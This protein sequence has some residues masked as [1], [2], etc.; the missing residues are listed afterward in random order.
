MSSPSEPEV[1]EPEVLAEEE[2]KVVYD[3][4]L[5]EEECLT[6]GS[7]LTSSVNASPLGLGHLVVRVTTDPEVGA[8]AWYH[9][10]EKTVNIDHAVLDIRGDEGVLL[11]AVLHEL[12]HAN[13]TTWIIPKGTSGAVAKA[14]TW[15]EEIRIERWVHDR[16]RDPGELRT[17][18]SWLLGSLRK[19]PWPTEFAVSG[20]WALAVGRYFSGVCAWSEVEDLDLLVRTELGDGRVT[21]M[22]EILSEAL[23]TEVEPGEPEPLLALAQEWVDLFPDAEEPMVMLVL[24]GH[25]SE[26][27]DDEE[28][29]GEEGEG[30]SGG[31]EGDEG[32]EPT[33]GSAPSKTSS[34]TPDDDAPEDDVPGRDLPSSVEDPGVLD[35][36]EDAPP[37]KSISEETAEMLKKK[38]DELATATEDIE[39]PEGPLERADPVKAMRDVV[40]QDRPARR[41]RYGRLNFEEVVPPAAVRARAASLSRTLENLHLPAVAKMKVASPGPPGRLH[42][43]EM[44]RKSADRSAGRMSMATPWKST[45]RI[46]TSHKPIRVGTMTDTSGSMHW[47]ERLVAEFAWITATAGRKIGARTA[48]VTFGDRVSPVVLPEQVPHT[49]K[50]YAADGGTEHFDVA[51]AAMDGF[52][53]L[54]HN[55]GSTK[56]LFIVSDGQLVIHDEPERAR[57]WLQQWTRAGVLVFWVGCDWGRSYYAMPGVTFVNVPDRHSQLIPE[58]ESVLTR[59]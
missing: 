39:K 19:G 56:V 16:L 5:T 23:E 6:L 40:A 58:L 15:L 34:G 32:E 9:H 10:F 53:K 1:L 42:G 27:H 45:K 59:I 44:V 12:G 33:S 54:S 18:F 25:S 22:K 57:M 48:A 17:M 4:P 2:P 30:S 51:A 7:A 13:H 8:P 50:V 35:P 37:T 46:R 36:E 3:P 31:E 20:L 24:C 21:H 11:G 29:E 49:M 55:D 47:A 38:L 14:V 26:D 52:L 28:G 41:G 43:R